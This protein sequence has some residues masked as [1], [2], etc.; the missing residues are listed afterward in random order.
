M[1]KRI[2]R[3]TFR[4]DYF[5]W[6]CLLPLLFS[7]ADL[8]A[9]EEDDEEIYELSPFEVQPSSGYVAQR[10]LSGTRLNSELIDVPQ[11]ISVLTREFLDDIAATTPQDAM[12]YS[13]NV[14][15]L[16]EFSDPAG[17]NFNRGINFNN[18]SGRVRGVSDAGRMRDFFETNLQG[19]TYNLEQITVSSGPNAVIYG[20]GGTGGII[21][22][23]FKRALVGNDAYTM[24]VRG[25]SEGSIRSTLDVN[26]VL[27][28]DRLAIRIIGL[29][30]DFNTYRNSSAGEQDRYFFTLTA[31]P[32]NGAN[33]QA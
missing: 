12:L 25:D 31:R 5:K 20:L 3:N 33:I 26:K 16:D 15:N 7:W 9:Q 22:T 11:Q 10:T 4:H 32:W 13:L 1:N 6:F 2:I 23:S 19:D 8:A 28:E 18:F 21:N 29:W 24:E 14:E 17:S 30:D 27:I